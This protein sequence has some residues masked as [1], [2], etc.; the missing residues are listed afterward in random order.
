MG[1]ML[2]EQMKQQEYIVI[3]RLI[4]FNRQD[5]VHTYYISNDKCGNKD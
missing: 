2:K 3:T 5:T 1:H 4:I